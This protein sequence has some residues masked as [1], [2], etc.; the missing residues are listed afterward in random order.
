MKSK[1]LQIHIFVTS[2]AKNAKFDESELESGGD[3]QTDL[4]IWGPHHDDNLTQENLAIARETAPFTEIDIYRAL[5]CP[6]S[7]P[8]C[9]GDIIVHNG[10]PNWG[11]LFGPIQ[12]RHIGETIGVMFC[13][14]AIVASELKKNCGNFT[15]STTNTTFILHKENF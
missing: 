7:E 13:G 15:D 9:I 3:K 2:A 1:I 5:F 8:I 12:Q 14:P 6:Q 11:D 10:R 4:A